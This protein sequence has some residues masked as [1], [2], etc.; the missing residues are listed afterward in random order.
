MRKKVIFDVFGVSDRSWRGIGNIPDS[1][2][3]VREKYKSYDAE[4]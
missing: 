4:K 1:G 2:Y 3:V